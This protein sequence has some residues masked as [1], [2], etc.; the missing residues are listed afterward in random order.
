MYLFIFLN[1]SS[2][3]KVHAP[4]HLNGF[5]WAPPDTR[6]W[7]WNWFI[8]EFEDNITWSRWST[9]PCKGLLECVW[10]LLVQTTSVSGQVRLLKPAINLTHSTY[11]QR[12]IDTGKNPQPKPTPLCCRA[13]W[14]VALGATQGVLRQC[15]ILVLSG[16][17]LCASVALIMLPA[18]SWLLL[19][20]TSHRKQGGCIKSRIIVMFQ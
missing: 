18:P 15:P 3:S 1:I 14:G 16:P 20:S 17:T 5:Y 9:M 7:C 4:H 13:V 2:H 8:V 6:W 12:Q 11:P 10:W 19:G